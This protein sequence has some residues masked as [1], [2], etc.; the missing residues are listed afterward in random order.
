MIL[1]PWIPLL[2]AAASTVVFGV[3]PAMA[4]EAIDSAC[5]QD[6]WHRVPFGQDTTDVS[7]YLLAAGRDRI[8]VSAH[9]ERAPG[10]VWQTYSAPLEGSALTLLTTLEGLRLSDLLMTPAHPNTLAWA[11]GFG[12]RNL[13]GAP[14]DSPTG[15]ATRGSLTD[16]PA[17]LVASGP[18]VFTLATRPDRTPG[19]YRWDGNQPNGGEWLL[20]ST[21]LRDAANQPVRAAWASASDA[22]GRMWL[23]ADRA[24][25]WTSTDG[26]TWEHR[27]SSPAID[28]RYST[29]TGISVSPKDPQRVAVG[30]GPSAVV[31]PAPGTNASRGVL[32]ST[33]GGL[34]FGRTTFP[35]SLPAMTD[36]I[37]DIAFSSTRPERLFATVWGDG[38]WTSEDGGATWRHL[39]GPLEPD[40]A[41]NR[42]EAASR[43]YLA[44][45]EVVQPA[46]DATCELLFVG[47]EGGLWV[48][49]VSP[50]R[51][52]QRIF[53][54]WINRGN[55]Q[56]L[57]LSA[58]RAT[59]R[60][61]DRTL[62]AIRR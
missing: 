1:R 60:P 56:Q 16:W 46:L 34:T 10:D 43:I 55:T 27:G 30:L 50:L 2:A 36:Q 58:A 20:A 32:T 15:F 6:G 37:T 42:H 13:F 40:E 28:L 35:G 9:L 41:S 26:G 4:Q 52:T 38:L 22:T 12:D 29:V 45:L 23:G 11:S 62:P 57:L 7:V 59:P 3:T 53:L 61:L 48:R 54:P 5:F 18:D 31:T 47:G 17:R 8:Y 25:L 24:G 39:G 14:V 49:D 33:D 44:V 19:V 51:T 21:D